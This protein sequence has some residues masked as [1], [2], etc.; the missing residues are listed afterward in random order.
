MAQ[1]DPV[2]ADEEEA[3]KVSY[4]DYYYWCIGDWLLENL[5]VIEVALIQFNQLF[6]LIEAGSIKEYYREIYQSDLPKLPTVSVNDWYF[7]SFTMTGT[8]QK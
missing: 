6:C 5:Y 1:I 4:G 2:F 3:Y 8:K 7:M